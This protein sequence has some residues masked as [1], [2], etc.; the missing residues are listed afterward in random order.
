M[1]LFTGVNLVLLAMNGVRFGGDTPLYLDGA[2]RMLY[3]L[4][5]VDRQ[6]SYAGYVAIVAIAQSIG[7][8]NLGVVIIQLLLGAIAAAAVYLLGAALAGRAA[9]LIASTLYGVDV[10]TN[11]WHQFVLADSIYVSLMTIGV[12]LTHRAAV[13]RGAEPLV[14]AL[15]VLIATGFV[16]PEGWFLLPAAAGYLIVM[17]GQSVRSRLGGIA[18]LCGGAAV[19]VVVI[20]PSYQGNLQAVGPANMLQR[21]QTIWDFD[22]WLVAMPPNDVA[23][24]DQARRAVEYALRHPVSTITLMAARVGVHFAHVRPFYS[25]LHNVAIVLWLL[26][27]YGAALYAAARLKTS[28]LAAWIIAAIASQTLVVALTH[29]EWDGRYLA[30]VLPLIDIFVGVGVALLLGKADVPGARPAYA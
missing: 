28:P 20:A 23:A 30:H 14:S 4:P 6:S 24:G 10:D 5:L 2:K 15:A 12:W 9:G 13:R 29:A 18:A 7:L 26:P 27:V 11:R 17:R 25:T 1:A 21:G 19:F 22:G 16:R 8:G 3:G